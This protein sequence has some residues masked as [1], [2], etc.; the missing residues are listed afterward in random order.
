LQA[1]KDNGTIELI[2]M[3]EKQRKRRFASQLRSHESWFLRHS[4]RTCS[5]VHLTRWRRTID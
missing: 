4:L 3:L 2:L 1:K 5:I